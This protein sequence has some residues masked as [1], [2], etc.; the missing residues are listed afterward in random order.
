MTATNDDAIL[1]LKLLSPSDSVG[2]PAIEQASN[3]S[4][5]V[6]C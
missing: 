2:L 6:P 1:Q 5:A 3:G 4:Q